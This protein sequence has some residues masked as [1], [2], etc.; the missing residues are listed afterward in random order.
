MGT[1]YLR[2]WESPLHIELEVLLLVMDSMLHHSTCQHF[3][4]DCK[5]LL[6]MI[7]DPQTWPDFSIEF[8]ELREL[9][10]ISQYFKINY[11]MRDKL[12][13]QTT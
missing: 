11:I 7:E 2:R 12:E 5:D 10:N 1:R 9:N 4:K 3:H 8:K 13:L 6:A